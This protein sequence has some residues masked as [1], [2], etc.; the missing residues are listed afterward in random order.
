[1]IELKI[2]K[3]EQDADVR[4][5]EYSTE[6]AACFDIKAYMPGASVVVDSTAINGVIIPTGLKFEVPEGYAMM[7]YSR[8]GQGFNSNTRL[9]NCVGVIDADYRGEVKVKLVYDGGNNT[10]ITVKHGDKIAQAM[11]IPVP[12]VE[13]KLVKDLS[14]TKRGAKGFGSTG[15]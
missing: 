7:I 5:P 6:G 8:S 11:L 10:P 1:M 3:V 13:L 12:K 15:V 4:M 9:S 2:E 14:K